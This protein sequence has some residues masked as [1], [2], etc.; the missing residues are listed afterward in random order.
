MSSG[1]WLDPDGLYRKYGTAKA[2]ASAG[3]DYLSFG[4]TREVEVKIDL[5]TLTSSAAVVS[6]ADNIFFP[7]DML[8]EQVE[9]FT[10]TGA[11]GGTSFSVGVI[12]TDRSTTVS[13]TAFVSGMLT[14]VVATAGDKV[15]L[16]VGSTG[17]GNKLGTTT[18][19]AGYISAKAS[20]TYTDGVVKVRIRYRGNG[21][22]TQ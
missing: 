20:G 4:E 5:T 22:I 14:A 10:E 13:D 6:N 15:T 21:T 2:A 8:I 7:S 16:N 9:V 19:T 3:G 18:G 17:A 1:T 12:Q 11:T